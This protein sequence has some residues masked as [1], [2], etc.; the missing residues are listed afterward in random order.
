M[1]FEVHRL[2]QYLQTDS[3]IT[4]RLSH[5]LGSGGNPHQM[6]ESPKHLFFNIRLV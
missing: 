4:R 1:T 2:V 3:F 5:L 6:S